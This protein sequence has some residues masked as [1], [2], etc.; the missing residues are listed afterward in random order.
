MTTL[1]R[2]VR[3]MVSAVAHGN[4]MPYVAMKVSEKTGLPFYVLCAFLEQET[5]GG[6]NIFGHDP[7]IFVGAGKVTKT[8]YLS[9]KAQRDRDLAHRK[10]Q[11]VGPL[12]LTW[13]TYQDEADKRGGCWKAEISTTVGA[14]LIKSYWDKY[15][16]WHKVGKAF[17]GS[18]AY[19]TQIAA[20]I[21]KWKTFIRG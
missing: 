13:Y 12:Q 7:T 21:N 11:G 6:K 9:Y 16:D 20:R 19:G 10:M 1:P 2:K 5:G 17:N 8:K 14:E 15:H 18:D 4:K 3:D